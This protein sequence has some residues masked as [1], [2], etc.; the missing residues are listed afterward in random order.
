MILPGTSY[1]TQDAKLV[2]GYCRFPHKLPIV[3]QGKAAPS[4]LQ[5]IRYPRGVALSLLSSVH[6]KSPYWR[7]DEELFQDQMWSSVL[8]ISGPQT[9]GSE[10]NNLRYLL[11]KSKTVYMDSRLYK[12]SLQQ[13]VLLGSLD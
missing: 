8:E 13:K 10:D 5:N 11:S 2:G 9:V 7:L 6:L 1:R 4:S 12:R 3:F